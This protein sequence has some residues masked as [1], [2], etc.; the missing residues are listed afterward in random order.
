MALATSP[1]K[2]CIIFLDL[3]L[4]NSR[5]FPHL[6]HENLALTL[7]L[8]LSLGFLFTTVEIGL[9]NYGHDCAQCK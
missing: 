5:F 8:S 9:Y 1:S 7:F 3:K 2:L 4:L 6:R